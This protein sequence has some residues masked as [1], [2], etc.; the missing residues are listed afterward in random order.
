MTGQPS[1]DNQRYAK[2]LQVVADFEQL[3]AML[4]EAINGL[5]HQQATELE[6]RALERARE[7]ASLGAQLARE[8]ASRHQPDD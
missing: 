8:V 2:C 3:S 4:Q 7:Q 1:R 5:K 6:V